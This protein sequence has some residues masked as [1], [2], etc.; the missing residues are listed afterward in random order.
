V[1]QLERADAA[2]EGLLHPVDAPFEEVAALHGQH[3]AHGRPGA[4]APA[5]PDTVGMPAAA[6]HFTRA[7]SCRYIDA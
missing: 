5:T 4:S 3:A 6:L 2:I 7:S 1:H